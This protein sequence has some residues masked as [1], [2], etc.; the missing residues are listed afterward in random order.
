MTEPT[1]RELTSR[2]EWIGAFPVMRQLRT[3]LDEAAYLD[4]LDRM[5]ENGY[6][7]FGLFSDDELV[8]LAGVD[9]SVNMYYGRHLWVCEL[10]TDA[11]HRSEGYGRRL[12][13][14][15]VEWAEGMGCEKI[16]LSSGVQ[17]EEAHRFYEER[18]AMD[19]ASHVFTR[20][21]DR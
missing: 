11:D 12:F 17:R 5:T 9:V 4:Y 10:I 2:A 18:V 14:H 3:H 13:E 8:A 1:V 6:R 20:N 15:L 19:R 16:A 21:L 7:L